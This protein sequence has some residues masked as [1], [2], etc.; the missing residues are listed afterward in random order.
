ML[1]IAIVKCMSG[2]SCRYFAWSAGRHTCRMARI[3]REARASE[4]PRPRAPHCRAR[5]R[6]SAI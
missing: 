6:V 4:N 3:L 2:P 1:L 5:I